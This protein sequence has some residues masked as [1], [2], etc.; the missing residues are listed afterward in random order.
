MY[1]CILTRKDTR[2]KPN[3]KRLELGRDVSRLVHVREKLLVCVLGVCLCVYGYNS[4]YSGAFNS[5]SVGKS[6]KEQFRE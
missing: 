5:P 1:V 3:E 6:S 2:G 4:T